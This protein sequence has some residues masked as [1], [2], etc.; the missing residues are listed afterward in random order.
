MINW[1]GTVV[2]TGTP[3]VAIN[4]L[5]ADI[6]KALKLPDVQQRLAAGLP[7]CPRSHMRFASQGLQYE[8]RGAKVEKADIECSNGVIHVIDSVM[9]P[10][11]KC[12][13]P[14]LLCSLRGSRAASSLSHAR[15]LLAG[16]A[17]FKCCGAHAALMRADA[18]FNTNSLQQPRVV[19]SAWQ[20]RCTMR[21]A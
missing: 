12:V 21:A 20:H 4:R 13:P 11:V 16:T 10:D 14:R 2:P 3:V 9:I 17:E 15:A 1:Y 6:N 7:A 5:N 19:S 8:V 18:L